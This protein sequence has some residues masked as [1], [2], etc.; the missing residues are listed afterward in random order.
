VIGEGTKID[1]LVQVAHNVKIGRHC[2]IVAQSGISGSVVLGDFVVLGA[3]SGVKDHVTIGSGAQ[4]AALTGVMRDVP[5]R[6][7]MS[8]WPAQP[9]RDWAREVAALKKLAKREGE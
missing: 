1:N 6:A 3:R 8:G 5:P 7:V 9:F 4:L 2:V